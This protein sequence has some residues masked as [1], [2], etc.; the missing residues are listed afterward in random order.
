MLFLLVHVLE[1]KVLLEFCIQLSPPLMLFAQKAVC[2][3]FIVHGNKL[4]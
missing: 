4:H 2:P 3:S 1:V